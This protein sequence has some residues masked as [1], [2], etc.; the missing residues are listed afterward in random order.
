MYINRISL[1]RPVGFLFIR[2]Y[3]LEVVT[4]SQNQINIQPPRPSKTIDL[5]KRVWVSDDATQRLASRVMAVSVIHLFTIVPATQQRKRIGHMVYLFPS[6]QKA[7]NTKRNKRPSNH[8]DHL[9]REPGPRVRGPGPRTRGPGPRT[10]LTD[11]V[12]GPGPRTWST[13]LLSHM[14]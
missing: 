13:G 3:R 4:N 10:W 9:V 2:V 14:R 11:V 12:H 1:K 8:L 7:K 6:H 5:V